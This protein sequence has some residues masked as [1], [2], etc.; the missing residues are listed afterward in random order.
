M[1]LKPWAEPDPFPVRPQEGPPGPA[2]L[3]KSLAAIG[4]AIN[5]VRA[6]GWSNP[7][8]GV[9]TSR[10]K[11]T[12]TQFNAAGLLT[13]QQCSILFNSDDIARRIVTT[14]PGE[15]RRAGYCLET[16]DEQLTKDLL[17]DA[18][19]L[20]VDQKVFEAQ[21]WGKCFGGGA[22][23]LGVRDGR[24]QDMPLNEEGVRSIEFLTVLDRRYIHPEWMATAIKEG[25]VA[26]PPGDLP[27]HGTYQITSPGLGGM[28][29]LHSSR[30]IRFEGELTDVNTRIFLHGWSLSTLQIAYEVLQLFGMSFASVGH[31]LQDASQGVFKVKDLMHMIANNRQALLDRMQLVDTSR[32]VA[33]AVLLEADTEDFTRVSTQFASL[34]ELL[35]RIMQRMSAAC[36][37]P[38][39]LLMGRSAAGMNATGDSDFRAYYDS[40]SAEREEDYK[41]ALLKIYRLLAK[42]RGADPEQVRIRCN[43]LWEPTEQE[44]SL[45]EKQDAD[46]DV[47]Y[48]N[49]GV[50][51]PEEV[52][53]RIKKG[54]R[55]VSDTEIDAE[56]REK[57]LEI[58]LE[59]MKDPEMHK[60][61][62]GEPGGDPLPTPGQGTAPPA[63]APAAKQAKPKPKAKK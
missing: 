47:A 10:D 26:L 15:M 53:L 48:I 43:K 54:S 59:M 18:K 63:K 49:A 7:Y 1:K 17:E 42:A 55:K 57:S 27:I 3:A 32:S 12:A 39:T 51:H 45:T 61:A 44:Q 19:T 58:E 4:Q 33:R 41:P 22:L 31:L 37:V 16:D 25:N 8:T 52:A 6:D 24:T 36:R 62:V 56:A 28:S 11:M 60:P 20:G 30:I 38:V 46:R 13:S 50:L 34:P 5:G 21:C 9:G 35:D 2:A 14:R 40:V 29:V 23:I